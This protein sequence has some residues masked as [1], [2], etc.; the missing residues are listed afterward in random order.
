MRMSRCRQVL[1]QAV[2]GLMICMSRSLK[3]PERKLGPKLY[4]SDHRIEPQ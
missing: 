4:M 2:S 3:I 1:S